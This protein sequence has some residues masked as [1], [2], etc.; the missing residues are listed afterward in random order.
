MGRGGSSIVGTHAHTSGGELKQQHAY[1][2]PPPLVRHSWSASRPA[3]SIH[4]AHT[5]GD[6]LPE[7]ERV[8]LVRDVERLDREVNEIVDVCEGVLH[9]VG[10]REVEV[11]RHLGH[12]QV[13]VQVAA[14]P[15]LQLLLQVPRQPL[16]I[17]LVHRLHVELPPLLA[18]HCP[19]VLAAVAALPR[20]PRAVAVAA[21]RQDRL[22]DTPRPPVRDGALL[23]LQE[24]LPRR[25]RL[26]QLPALPVAHGVAARV[27]PPLEDVVEDV[28]LVLARRVHRVQRDA[29]AGDVREGDVKVDPHLRAP[30][31]VHLH[32]LHLLA[33]L[34]VQEL[35]N[36]QRRRDDN[37]AE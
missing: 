11:A 13:A 28:L 29:R 15:R 8:D 3:P 35:G 23:L 37:R 18:V 6:V 2:C 12:L 24:G 9:A 20:L 16:L 22:G 32:V 27:Y 14:L 26:L 4:P 21:P 1:P 25:H 5:H 30:D 10:G 7:R 33:S 19:H 36:E 17:A 34:V 31:G